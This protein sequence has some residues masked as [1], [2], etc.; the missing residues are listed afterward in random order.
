LAEGAEVPPNVLWQ[1][2]AEQARLDDER[3]NIRL[4]KESLNGVKEE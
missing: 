4:E 2:E 3:K 1:M